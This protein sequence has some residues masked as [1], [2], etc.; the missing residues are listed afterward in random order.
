[1]VTK[2]DEAVAAGYTVSDC[3]AG[4]FATVDRAWFSSL[5]ADGCASVDQAAAEAAWK[6]I[7]DKG[8]GASQLD[9]YQL[10][11]AILGHGVNMSAPGLHLL[12]LAVAESRLKQ[13][14][15]CIL[16]VGCGSGFCAATFAFLAGACGSS[17]VQVLG[18][19]HVSEF[20]D[21]ANATV[22]WAV[23]DLAGHIAFKCADARLMDAE[24]HAGK[25]VAAECEETLRKMLIEPLA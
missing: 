24:E 3:V 5:K 18:V 15:T 12:A 21:L 10:R 22:K 1:M 7:V 8:A 16:D 23:P 20:I 14:T 4:V 6:R 11:P 13:P 19:D 17:D 9:C 25:C 2:Y